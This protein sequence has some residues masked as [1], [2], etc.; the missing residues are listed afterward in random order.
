MGI[1]KTWW[2]LWHILGLHFTQCVGDLVTIYEIINAEKYHQILIYYAILSWKHLTGNSFV[3]QLNNDLRHTAIAFNVYLDS[4][5]TISISISLGLVKS[6][7]L[8]LLKQ[9]RIILTENGT[10]ASQNPKS[11]G[12]S[13]KKAGEL[14]LHTASGNSE[15]ACECSGCVGG[16]LTD[17][18]QEINTG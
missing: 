15:T 1:Y 5:N 4:W 18:T 17:W 14:F 6:A 7:V 2:W 10:K 16:W 13:F 3:F 9:C 8:I 11:F 12:M